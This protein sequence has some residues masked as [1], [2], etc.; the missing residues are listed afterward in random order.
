MKGKAARKF[1][2]YLT[3]PDELKGENRRRCGNLTLKELKLHL[4]NVDIE[5]LTPPQALQPKTVN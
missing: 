1:K 3:E 4:G 5:T 2:R